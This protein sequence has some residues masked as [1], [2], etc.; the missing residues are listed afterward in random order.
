MDKNT[1]GVAVYLETKS[2]KSVQ[3]KY[4]RSFNFNNCSKKFQISCQVKKFK[5]TGSSI[6]S[7]QR[8]NEFTINSKTEDGYNS[9][10]LQNTKGRMR[11][12]YCQFWLKAPSTQTAQRWTFKT[13]CVNVKFLVIC[14]SID[15]RFNFYVISFQN[16]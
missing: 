1:F 15:A 10:D 12:G 5:E 7:P 4:C 8:A 9:A 3:A 14:S 2:F 13:C 6:L 16:T 11:Q